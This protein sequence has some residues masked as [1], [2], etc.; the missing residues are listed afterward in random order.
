M[1]R[2]FWRALV[3]GV[4]VLPV[5][6]VVG[7]PVLSS[8]FV[9][10][11]RTHA[12]FGG[13]TRG[14]AGHKGRIGGVEVIQSHARLTGVWCAW[15]TKT[16][17]K[18]LPYALAMRVRVFPGFDEGYEE[19][20]A[21]WSPALELGDGATDLVPVTTLAYGWPWVSVVTDYETGVGLT[22]LVSRPNGR[23][24]IPSSA[25]NGVAL[26]GSPVVVAGRHEYERRAPTRVVWGGAM[27]NLG[28]YATLC[29][30]AVLPALV[31]PGLVRESVRRCRGLCPAC[32]YN[33]GD[34][35]RCPEC[36]AERPVAQGVSTRKRARSVTT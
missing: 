23:S 1:R 35:D 33:V 22:R 7:H 36:G 19:S 17:Q 20:L 9:E 25:I 16:S 4:A 32:G 26:P 31:V 5:V 11:T 10:D 8:L 13:L 24:V 3:V 12:R 30:G 29:W 18:R 15:V 14:V 2:L 34:F 28:V 21:P 6:V 27:K